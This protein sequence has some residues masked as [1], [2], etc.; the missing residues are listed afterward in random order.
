MSLVVKKSKPGAF[1]LEHSRVYNFT[2]GPATLPQIVLEEAASE[3]LNW[4]GSGMSILEISHRDKRVMKMVD[5]TESD[6]LELLGLKDG[7]RVLFIQGG[8]S[9]QFVMIPMNFAPDKMVSD[10]VN[11]GMWTEKAIK[12]AKICGSDARVIGSSEA[13]NFTYIPR[14][15]KYSKDAKYLYITSN[16]TIRGTQWHNFPK[17]SPSPLIADMSSEF[18]SRPLDL[19]KFALIH[20][21]AQKNV[22][23]AGVTI[24]VI[25]SDFA[26]EGK[27]GLPHLLDYRT[28]METNSMYNT[29]PVFAIYVAGL[30]MKWLKNTI[31]GLE[32]MAQINDAK[33]KKLYSAIDG[34]KGFY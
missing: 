22:G 31:G 16:N 14:D 1:P 12:E 23:P 17:D 27:K 33:A 19:S 34:S 3:L 20:A 5:E 4:H 21:G 8:A 24:V 7:W 10:Y 29:P 28:Y 11:T 30:I 9:L 6:V 26:K 32:K 2:G 18:L 15:L 13:D 25:R